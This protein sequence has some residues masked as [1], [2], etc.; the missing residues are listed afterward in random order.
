MFSSKTVFSPLNSYIERN[1]HCFPKP[2]KSWCISRIKSRQAILIGGYIITF[3]HLDFSPEYSYSLQN[4]KLS[5]FFFFF[6]SQLNE[7]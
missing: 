4:L 6:A 1:L 3:F 2:Y 5:F 7:Y